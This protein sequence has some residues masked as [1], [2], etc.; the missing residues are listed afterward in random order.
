MNACVPCL[1]RNRHGGGCEILHLLKLEVQ[2]FGQD[3]QF[4]HVFSGAARVGTDEVGN[5]LLSQVLAL[6]DVVEDALEIVEELERGF[7]HK[8]EH[9]VGGV[10]RSYLQAT[11]DVFDDEFLCIFLVGAIDALI[12]CVVKQ[13][14]VAH[15]RTDETLLD[16]G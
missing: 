15:T 1:S 3:S 2:V 6:V 13:Q 12:A 8:V 11:A 7:A 5:D 16:E 4:S 14:I 10:F 9:A